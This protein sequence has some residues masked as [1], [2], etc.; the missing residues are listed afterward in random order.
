M[1]V[2]YCIIF[3][4]ELFLWHITVMSLLYK[5]KVNSLVSKEM[6]T[7]K[8]AILRG[9]NVIVLEVVMSDCVQSVIFKATTVKNNVLF[10]SMASCR[11]LLPC[12][13]SKRGGFLHINV[14]YAIGY[15]LFNLLHS[16]I[17]L[18]T[19]QSIHHCGSQHDTRDCGT[20]ISV[21]YCKQSP[22][23]GCRKLNLS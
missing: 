8:L 17:W 13:F 6:E 12:H 2:N 21:P 11:L 9:Y 10:V 18:L 14:F 3:C 1:Y 16:I 15:S 22:A 5:M 19:Q 7:L 23:A 4:K 20:C